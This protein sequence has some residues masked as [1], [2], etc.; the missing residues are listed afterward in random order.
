MSLLSINKLSVAYT[1]EDGP[2]P[3]VDTVSLTI[4]EGETLCLVGESGCGKSTLAMAAP[5]LLPQPP[6][7]VSGEVIFQGKDLLSLPLR[8]MRKV[9]GRH[10]GVIFQD[11]MSALS[12]LMRIGKQMEETFLLHTN[13]SPQQR[14]DRSI[15][16]LQRVGLPNPEAL[17]N[18]WP[19]ELS[20]GMKQRVMIAMAL[21]LEPELLIADEPTTALDVV[22]QNQILQLL[23]TLCH[24][25]NTALWLITHDMGV[26]HQMAD[27]VM[28]MYAGEIVE[29]AVAKDFFASPRHPYSRALL[30]AIPSAKTKGHALYSIPG[31]VPTPGSWGNYCRFAERCDLAQ[32]ECRTER[33]LFRK[34]CRC[35]H[36]YPMERA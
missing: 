15:A 11:P 26:V 14:R 25:Q 36:P 6:A 21:A 4:E 5:R 28:V 8:E 24:E 33:I 9:R 3:T 7:I 20:G 31:S 1:H 18:A 22:I 27:R 2:C 23:R 10:I 29:S 13:L 32:P 16:W 12:P 34:G 17:L 30:M 35:K 19:H